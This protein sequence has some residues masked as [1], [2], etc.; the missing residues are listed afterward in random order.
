MRDNQSSPKSSSQPFD[1]GLVEIFTGNG[2][3][4]TTAA[5]GVALRAL[6]HNLRVHIIYF[7]KGSF[8]Y[9]E[10]QALA[11]LPNISFSSFGQDYFVDPA[12]VKPEEKEEARKGLE[13]AREVIHSGNYDLVILDE[14]NVA[15]GWKLLEV[16][17]VLELIKNK[18]KNVELILTGRYADPTLIDSA[19]LVTEMVN[20][21]HPYDRG[22]EA[23]GGIDY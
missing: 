18:P 12:N 8:P 19:D 16:D 22:I 14:I 17:E 2:K 9:S 23:R 13:K 21:K 11:Q 7:M 3:G 6:G 4:K 10:Q 20:I 1:R 5:L 15:V